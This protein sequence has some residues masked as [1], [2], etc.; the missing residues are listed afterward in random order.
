LCG[1]REPREGAEAWKDEREG[2][3]ERGSMLR[4]LVYKGGRIPENNGGIRKRYYSQGD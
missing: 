1:A 4:D 3:W 2:R